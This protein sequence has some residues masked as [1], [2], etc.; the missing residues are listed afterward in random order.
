MKSGFTI[1]LLLCGMLFISS[2]K[3]YANPTYQKRLSQLQSLIQR[4]VPYDSKTSPDTVIAWSEY[5]IPQIEVKGNEEQYFLLQLQ[6][7]KA[8]SLLGDISLAMDRARIMYEE[9]KAMRY[10]FGIV[11]ANQAIGEAYAIAYLSDKALDSFDD[12]LNEL[13]H[14][15][16]DHPYRAELLLQKSHVLQQIGR[17]KEAQKILKE[18][19]V[20]LERHP[21]QSLSFAIIVEETNYAISH[22]HLSQTYLDG[23][24]TLLQ[25]LESIYNQSPEKYYRFTIDYTKAAYYRAKGEWDKKY[26]DKAVEAYDSLLRNVSGN[27]RSTYYRWISAEKIHLYK[28]Q[29]RTLEACRIY[30]ELFPAT[31]TIASQSYVRQIDALRAKYQVDQIE[32]ASEGE[33][34]KVITSLSVGSITLLILFSFIALRLREQKKKVALSTQKLERSRQN[35]E[36][37]MHAKSIFLSNM[38]HEI[39]TPLNALSGFSSLLTEDGLD[40]ETR[41]QC[42]E[43]IQQNSELLLK[44]INDVID[45]SSLEFGKMQFSIARH[46]A[47]AICKN[48]VDTVSKVKQTQA[49]VLFVTELEQLEIETDDSRLQQVLINLLINSTKFTP[50]GSITLKLEK[51]SDELALFS[52]TDTGCGIPLE[53]Q[54]QI[55]QRFEKLNENAQGSGL[56]LSICQLIIEHIGGKIWIDSEY[57]NGSRFFF[58]HPINQ[59]PNGKEDK[60]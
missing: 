32:I 49:E 3:V 26:W 40:E 4:G 42:N 55:F 31:D 34:N 25:K 33:Y 11:L 20:F 50:Q 14:I 19:N 12:A 30:Q 15:A 37:A 9:A 10:D 54:A 48:V 7:T 39:R 28:I 13:S 52:V 36:N 41:R 56:G 24:K 22:G 18:L 17:M 53:K 58:T 2:T 51:Q 16:G 35:A 59:K 45:L 29:G 38:S 27:K 46:D 60:V 47:V 21:S 5:V 1:L 44:L 43:V 8:Y 23:A 6:L 57:A